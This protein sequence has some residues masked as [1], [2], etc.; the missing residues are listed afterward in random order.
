M[1]SLNNTFSVLMLL[2]LASATGQIASA[3]EAAGLKP[4]AVGQ[5]DVTS[6]PPQELLMPDPVPIPQMSLDEL[7]AGV[8]NVSYRGGQLFVDADN[9]TLGDVLNAIGKELGAQIETPGAAE[10]ER[11]AAHLSGPPGEVIQSLLND[12]KFSYIIL[13]PQ[14]DS[15]R[16]QKVILMA[17]TQAPRTALAA[18][19]P[20]NPR[21]SAAFHTEPRPT[22]EYQPPSVEGATLAGAAQAPPSGAQPTGSSSSRIWNGRK[23]R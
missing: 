15:V 19:K 7:P 21:V 5:Q 18:Q 4:A 9:A 12:G 14:Q 1:L 20:S 16:V 13:H 2:F 10:S 3:A 11:V 17:V 8:P 6:A 22:P 23:L